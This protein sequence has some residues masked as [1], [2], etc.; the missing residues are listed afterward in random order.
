MPTRTRTLNFKHSN[1]SMLNIYEFI[2]LTTWGITRILT[3]KFYNSN[4]SSNVGLTSILTANILPVILVYT[5]VSIFYNYANISL[6][7][8]QLNN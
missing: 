4:S 7:F 8:L 3:Y 2:T 6:H 5:T 1:N